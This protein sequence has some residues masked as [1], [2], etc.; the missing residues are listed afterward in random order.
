MCSKP[1]ASADQ[2]SAP[3]C[4]PDELRANIQK[5]TGMISL[6]QMHKQLPRRG[7]HSLQNADQ[8]ATLRNIDLLAEDAP[9]RLG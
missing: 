8:R 5:L 3:Q 9:S 1:T 2:I 7:V 4:S 6:A